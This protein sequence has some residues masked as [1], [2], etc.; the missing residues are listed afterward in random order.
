MS[1]VSLLRSVTRPPSNASRS[2]CGGDEFAAATLSVTIAAG[3]A[4]RASVGLDCALPCCRCLVC[5]TQA[6]SLCSIAAGGDAATA[7][8]GFD[9][10]LSC[11]CCV[12]EA[13]SLWSIGFAAE[14]GKAA[15]ASVDP[16]TCGV[17]PSICCGILASLCRIGFVLTN[18]VDCGFEESF[19]VC[20]PGVLSTRLPD[21]GVSAAVDTA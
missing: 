10:V 7:S 17:L 18:D 19:R 11:G 20:K 16:S 5:V 4:A 9:S 3:D 14:D 6:A 13:A 2:A 1:A 12:T 15:T 8:A 21:T